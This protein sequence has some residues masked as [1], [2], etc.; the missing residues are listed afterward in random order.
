MQ[1]SARSN[2]T[3]SPFA[4]P[5]GPYGHV[6]FG[7]WGWHRRWGGGVGAGYAPEPA[8]F[9]REVDVI[10]RDLGSSK[11]VYESRAVSDGP[12]FDNAKV[13]P[14]MFTAA[15]QGF[16]NPPAGPRQ[17]NIDLPS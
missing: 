3:L 5:S 17:V 16:P 1:I 4:D 9:H 15:M 2:P 12:Y 6:G 14:A 10:V 7:G 11:V 13:F 8:W